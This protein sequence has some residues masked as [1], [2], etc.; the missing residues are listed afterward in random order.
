[1]IK[2]LLIFLILFLIW[3]SSAF[4]AAG[5]IVSARI[6]STGWFMTITIAGVD[7]GGVY[8][9]ELGANGND[10]SMAKVVL[11]LTSQGYD[12]TGTLGT[13]TRTV[14]G[15]NAKRQK[16]PRDMLKEETDYGTDSV[17]VA[18]ALSE[19]IYADDTAISLS[20]DD[21]LYT[22]GGVISAAAAKMDVVNASEQPYSAAKVVAN[23]SWPG[24]SRSPH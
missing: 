16:Y 3:V 7:T 8:D 21:S 6:D 1:M 22:Q 4:G 5:D 15:T 11:T 18:V 24:F 23:W 12:S 13:L 17:S 9:F 10:P 2:K 20:L 19:W 14:Y